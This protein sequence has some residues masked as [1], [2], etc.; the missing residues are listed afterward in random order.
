MG[1]GTPRGCVCIILIFSNNEL[2]LFFQL[3]TGVEPSL[4]RPQKSRFNPK[5]G[6][7]TP[8]T[9]HAGKCKPPVPPPVLFAPPQSEGMTPTGLDDAKSDGSSELPKP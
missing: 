9:P 5:I 6:E 1:G 7:M 4:P 3:T 2:V 8:Q